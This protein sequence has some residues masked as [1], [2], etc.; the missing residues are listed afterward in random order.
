MSL[1]EDIHWVFGTALSED[2]VQEFVSRLPDILYQA[3]AAQEDSQDRYKMKE[4]FYQAM[5]A[6]IVRNYK[7][8]NKNVDPPVEPIDPKAPEYLL[9]AACEEE[10]IGEKIELWDAQSLAKQQENVVSALQE[11]LWSAKKMLEK[12]IEV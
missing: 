4:I 3:R 11:K 1:R 10:L 7:E 6:G 5:R 9:D 12:R 2:N 8:G